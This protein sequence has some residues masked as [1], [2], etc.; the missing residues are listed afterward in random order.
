VL[1]YTPHAP[2]LRR[3]FLTFVRR[4]GSLVAAAC[5]LIVFGALMP[6]PGFLSAPRPPAFPG[7]AGGMASR[8][9]P[10]SELPAA[11]RLVSFAPQPGSTPAIETFPR[12]ALRSDG[13][14]RPVAGIAQ[15]SEPDRRWHH[16]A[17]AAARA[18]RG[19]YFRAHGDLVRAAPELAV[20]YTL[21]EQQVGPN[22]PAT[23]Q[24][25]RQLAGV[26]QVALNTEDRDAKRVVR[27]EMAPAP[28]PVPAPPKP[29]A[30]AWVLRDQITNRPVAEVRGS[31]VP[32]LAQAL[33]VARTVEERRAL[34]SALGKLGPAARDAVPVLAERVHKSNDP[35]EVHA[36]LL[37]LREMGPAVRPALVALDR[38]LDARRKELCAQVV[39]CLDGREWRVGVADAGGY[40][41]VRQL[42]E[43]TVALRN[44]ACICEV[45]VLIETARGEAV[46]APANRLAEMGPK[47][48]HVRIDPRKPAVEVHAS[49]AIRADGFSAEK[50]REQMLRRLKK[51][52]YDGALGD[53]VRFVLRL[54]RQ[55]PKE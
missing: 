4:R 54:E 15:I 18:R 7:L 2:P 27:L 17:H 40:F 9:L 47:A 26:Y 45:E 21:C 51:R 22:H 24:A 10:G 53:G 39:R 44:L 50:L 16:A 1:R 29:P 14:L 48:I 25:V 34:V 12:P 55:A 43:A 8:S 38:K 35:V 46:S 42:R 13:A 32:I 11:P 31:I 3:R 36:A 52:Q 28:P 33:H 30:S 41:S 37:A 23:R 19:M 49:E 5:L 6:S 20:A